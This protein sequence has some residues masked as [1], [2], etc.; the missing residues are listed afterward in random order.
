VA[1]CFWIATGLN[2]VA[3]VNQKP[4]SAGFELISSAV[5]LMQRYFPAKMTN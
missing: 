1:F 3:T 2:P 4:V 5:F